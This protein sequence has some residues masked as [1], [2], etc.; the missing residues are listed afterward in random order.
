MLCVQNCSSEKEAV[1]EVKAE[2]RLDKEYWAQAY[3][4]LLAFGA[5]FA[6]DLVRYLL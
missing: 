5:L 4:F 3:N 1:T 2:Y 6:A